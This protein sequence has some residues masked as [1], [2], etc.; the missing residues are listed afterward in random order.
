MSVQDHFTQTLGQAR[1][2]YEQAM[3]DLEANAGNQGARAIATAINLAGLR[4]A[5]A[6]SQ[7]EPPSST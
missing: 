4:I 7:P 5:A 3:F 2:A 6:I 1:D